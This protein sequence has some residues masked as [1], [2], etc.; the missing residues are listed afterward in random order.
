MGKIRTR[1]LGLEE[2]EKKQKEEQKKRKQEKKKIRAPG[3]K[4]GERMVAVEVKEEEM[5]K[6]EKAKKILEE[7]PKATKKEEEKKFSQPQKKSRGKKYQ[8]LRKMVDKNKSYSIKE[9]ITLLKKMNQFNFDQTVELHLNVDKTGLKGE[10]E[11]PYSIGKKLR[12]AIVDDKI[13]AQIEKGE[14][15]F[16][17]LITHPSYMPKLAKFARIL[18]PKGL[19]PN[20]KAGTISDKPEEVAKKFEKGLLRWK[21]EPKF[22]LIHQAVGKLSLDEEKLVDNA[23]VFLKSVGRAHIRSVFVKATM[24]PSIKLSL[25][26]LK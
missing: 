20:P 3:L 13:L 21:T 15:N 10:V 12:V 17:V 16:D 19:M 1:I 9:A 18:G 7:K 11:L 23:L 24:T 6:L 22:P 14:L 26:E 5:E 2:V 8:E 4:G 25:E